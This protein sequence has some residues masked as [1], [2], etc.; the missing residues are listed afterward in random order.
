MITR[1]STPPSR[2]ISKMLREIKL[3]S[4]KDIMIIAIADKHGHSLQ[5][6]QLIE[7]WYVLQ[8]DKSEGIVLD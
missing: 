3:W 2:N 8:M 5:G 1:S 6:H 4:N 7:W